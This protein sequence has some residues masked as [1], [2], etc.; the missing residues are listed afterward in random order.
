MNDLREQILVKALGFNPDIRWFRKAIDQLITDVFSAACNEDFLYEEK[1]PDDVYRY[2]FLKID[3]CLEFIEGDLLTFLTF[4][5]DNDEESVRECIDIHAR[6][7]KRSVKNISIII[8]STLEDINE[9][10]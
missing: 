5:A 8:N 3:E 6:N 7:L 9:E 1:I 10:R 4:T 2:H